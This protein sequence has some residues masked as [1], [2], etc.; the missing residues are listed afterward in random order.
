[1]IKEGL[2]ECAIRVG[3]PVLEQMFGYVLENISDRHVLDR[4][5]SEHMLAR[6]V[7]GHMIGL[8]KY[9]FSREKK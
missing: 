7:L 6:Q 9:Y 3:L 2:Q 5:I 4:H 1:M 8:K